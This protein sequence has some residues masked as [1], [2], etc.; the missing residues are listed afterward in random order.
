[1]S[2]IYNS[3]GW[4]NTINNTTTVQVWTN[5]LGQRLDRQEYVLP[6]AFAGKV[7]TSVT[8]T[9]KGNEV[10]SR[11]ILAALTVSTC[12]AHVAEGITISSGSITYHKETAQYT[13][14]VT[15]TNEGSAAVTGPVYLF[16]RHSSRDQSRKQIES[17]G[18]LRADGQPVSDSASQGIVVG[19]K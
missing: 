3:D 6:Q 5:G 13:Q 2:A 7:L 18:L 16:G 4:Q 15:L 8:I 10:F 1:M 12:D 14:A 9:D 11:A 19:A 17:D